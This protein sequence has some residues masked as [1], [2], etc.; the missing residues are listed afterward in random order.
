MN[1]QYGTRLISEYIVPSEE[2]KEKI[3]ACTVL[4]LDFDLKKKC[5]L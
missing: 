1:R 3:S 2:Q 5:F 4:S